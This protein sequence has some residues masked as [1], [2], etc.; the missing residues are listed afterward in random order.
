VPAPR[1]ALRSID[2]ITL[3]IGLVIGAGIFKAPSVVAA[4]TI[5]EGVMLAAWLLGGVI[6]LAGALCYAELASSY[7]HTGGEYHFLTRAYG[8][9]LA[10]LF[11]WSRL[12]VLQTGSIALLAFVFGDY[13]AATVPLGD[14]GTAIYAAL[15]VLILTAVNIAGLRASTVVQHVMTALLVLGLLLVSV[16][17]LATPPATPAPADTAA[18]SEFGLA[19]VF[20][21]LTY[22]G[23]NESAYVSAEL[24]DVR[25][26]MAR[27]L[28]TAIGIIT[29]LYLLANLAYLNALGF[30]G[31]RTSDVVTADAMRIALGDIGSG[32]VTALV[33]VAVLT[34]IN[35]TILT[36]ARTTYAL[37]NDYALFGLLAGWHDKT[38]APINALVVQGLISVLLVVAGALSRS[39]FETMVH[40]VSPIFWL[41]FM[42]TALSLFVL[43]RRDG[44]RL[45][46]F[47]VPL[48]PA[49]PLLFGLSC[50]YMLYASL[51]YTGFGALLGVIVLAAGLPLLLIPNRNALRAPADR[52]TGGD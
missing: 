27:V 24:R 11:A 31:M 20:V 42:L 38:N 6:S 51:A 30:A 37:A 19:M 1:Q 44:A 40:Y 7:P 22:G 32:L 45:R 49:T 34:S 43:R 8:R 18:T 33:S 17:G 28:V 48:Y 46:P 50:A 16:A 35:V 47:R 9:R 4:N 41:F 23:W 3:I 25:R 12:T 2:V 36:G 21:L 13:L 29:L 14:H 15:A 52:R 5:S 10:F 39:G 26:N